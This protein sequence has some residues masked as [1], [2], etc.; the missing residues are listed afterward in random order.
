MPKTT[1]YTLATVINSGSFF[2]ISQEV[3]PGVYESQ[4][5]P[6]SLMNS[7]FTGT[8]IATAN[9]TADTAIRSYTLFGDTASEQLVF[10]NNSGY[11]IL[12]INGAG[13]VYSKGIENIAG[14]TFYGY[15]SGRNATAGNNTGIGDTALANLTTGHDNVAIGYNAMSVADDA[16][17]VEKNFNSVFIGV[18]AKP[19]ADGT[20]NEIGI[21]YNVVGHGTNTVTIGNASILNN[22]FFGDLNVDG[23][24]GVGDRNLIVDSTGLIKVGA[25]IDILYHA[26]NTAAFPGTGDTELIYVADDTD[27]VYIWDADS[28]SYKK[29]GNENIFSSNGTLSDNT[30]T[31]NLKLD[32]DASSLDFRNLSGNSIIKIDG[33][34][35]IYFDKLQA[36]TGKVYTVQI[37]EDGKLSSYEFISDGDGIYGGNGTT[38]TS[39]EVTIA[40]TLT[41]TN[42][43][44]LLDDDVVIK[45]VNGGSEINLRDG[46]NSTIGITTDNGGY[47]E[48]YVYLDTEYAEIGVGT[49]FLDVKAEYLRFAS[50]FTIT[51]SWT[52]IGNDDFYHGIDSGLAGYDLNSLATNMAIRIFR[53]DGGKTISAIPDRGGISINSE[54]IFN[55]GVD[56]SVAMMGTVGGTVKTN[57]TV[58]VNQIAYGRG[59]YELR[60]TTES[61]T[62]SDKV[63]TYQNASGI[64]ALTSDL[65]SY[66]PLSGG[67]MTGNLN[68]GGYQ[69]QGGQLQSATD[70]FYLINSSA[71]AA[72]LDTSNITANRNIVIQNKDHTIA[73][74]DDIKSNYFFAASDET[75]ELN[76]GASAVFTDY[77]P[78]AITVS[79]I[80]IS[81]N[82]APTGANIIVDIHKNGTT[83]FTTLISIDAT[84]NTSLTA[85]TPYVLDGSISFAQGDKIEAFITQV[86]STIP[87]AGLKV[88]ILD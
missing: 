69:L 36:P 75:T 84:E 12:N 49:N 72:V 17:N 88:K 10:K 83:I 37:D 32:T 40:D 54:G 53:N 70:L 45:A 30:R 71:F 15:N 41:F 85:T 31:L 56:G 48:A 46:G 79:S 11:N 21:G 52:G 2:D 44:I 61:I 35:D 16:S 59:D 73:G 6:I 28:S 76:V 5:V 13:D 24:A 58:Y 7:E 55:T 80:M 51:D 1:D 3:S 9:L 26:T 57:S 68:M 20:S 87:G 18:N 23:L 78:Y 34:R 62:F 50:S 67:T 22:Y 82:T 39:T 14:N 74:L 27:F 4:K 64:I 66:L 19:L 86:G 47:A 8:N 25:G 33:L 43:V 60:L 65:S 77:L 63:Q 29:V 38:P 81:V 42:G